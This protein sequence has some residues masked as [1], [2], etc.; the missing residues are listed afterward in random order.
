MTVAL[1][2]GEMNQGPEKNHEKKIEA[3]K[4]IKRGLRHLYRKT[5]SPDESKSSLLFS[6]IIIIEKVLICAKGSKFH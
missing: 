2:L 6:F 1:Y 3:T 4:M 5:T